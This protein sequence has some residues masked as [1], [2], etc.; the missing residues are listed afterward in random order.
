MSTVVSWNGQ[1]YTV[2]STG[3]L[4]WGGTLKVDGLLISLAQNSLQKSGGL[5]TLSADVDFGGTAGL[6]ALYFLTRTASP[7]SVGVFRFANNEGI[8][9]RNA[10]NSANLVFKVN[11]S[12]QLEYN[13]AILGGII[14][15]TQGGTGQSTYAKGDTLYASAVNTLSKR[16]IAA[17]QALNYV[18]VDVPDW[19]A[20]GSASTLLTLNGSVLTWA[21][22][23]DANIAAAAG[24]TLSK[25]AALTAGKLLVSDG[26]GVI[27]VETASGYMKLTSGTPAYSSTIPRTDVDNGTADHVVINSGAGA[28][29]SEA[30]LAK[31]RG[32][33]GADMSSVTFPSS[34]TIATTFAASSVACAN[35]NGHG[36]TN[37]KIRRW[38]NATTVGTDITYADSATLGSTFTINTAGRYSVSYTDQLTSVGVCQNGIS[39]NSAQ[40]TTNID[41]IT[42]ANR[43]IT[44]QSAGSSSYANCS[45][46][47]TAAA[48]DVIR[49]HTNGS[50]NSTAALC[51]FRIE[52]IG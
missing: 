37:T 23:A 28:L 50:P 52:R 43:L 20:P 46:S 1:S 16:T 13:G 35:P 6:K 48:N 17:T 42:T 25:L 9:W 51:Q 27:S 12:D 34:G 18:N 14:P 21:L 32:G 26:A 36:S 5:F 11:A 4:N 7:S 33:A 45:V 15:A 24:I 2:P 47:F 40:L 49:T 39:I 19:L 10:A 30:T 31:V 8:G 29:S 38:T 44:T 22:L 41:S 3:E